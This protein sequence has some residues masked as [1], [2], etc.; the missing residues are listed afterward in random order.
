MSGFNYEDA[1]LCA[2]NVPLDVLA[3]S[4]GTPLYVYSKQAIDLSFNTLKSALENRLGR[5]AP[6]IAYAVKANSN[7]AVIKA[8]A[9]Q[10]AGADLVSGGELIRAIK[11]G[12]SPDKIV[13]SGV[14]KTGPELR[15]AVQHQ[16]H[17]IN[18]ESAFELEHLIKITDD[19]RQPVN[20]V[21]RI[22]PDVDAKTHAKITTGKKDNKFG[23]TM[24]LAP[25]LFDRARQAEFVNCVGVAIHI[26]SQLTDIQ[27]FRDAFKVTAEFV[28]S[29]RSKGHTVSR[30]DL[31][32]GLGIT[33]RD[34]IPPDLDDYASAIAEH[35]SNDEAELVIAPGRFL[36]GNAGVLLSRVIGV[37]Q[38]D[39][40]EFLIIDAA[41]NDL[42]RPSLYDAYH[43][44][45]PVSQPRGDATINYDVV[46]P[47]CETGD[48]FALARSLPALKEGDLVTLMS[49]GAYGAVMSSTYNSRDWIAE[50]LVDGAGHRLIRRRFTLDDQLKLEE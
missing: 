37:K 30:I 3:N 42:A 31:G 18:V 47:V 38:T 21:V 29:L 23:V 48:T 1:Q 10:G 27:P 5:K 2:D 11:A 19:M 13:F 17:Q 22:N 8:L 40:K 46:G 50:A 36:V 14:G 25:S 24:E 26:G 44:I 6:L 43:H 7:L 28:H 4:Y 20:V 16:I 39:E 35:F 45:L 9:E 15:L 41:M 32:G 33:Y 49:A 34:E 12:M